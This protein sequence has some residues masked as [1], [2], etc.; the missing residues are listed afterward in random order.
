MG[1]P[2][3]PAD[4]QYQRTLEFVCSRDFVNSVNDAPRDV[5]ELLAEKQ[6]FFSLLCAIETI[7]FA[8]V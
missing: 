1:K 8:F 3:S 5:Q 2:K 6:A 7:S 4:W